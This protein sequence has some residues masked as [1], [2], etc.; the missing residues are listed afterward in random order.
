MG[1][2][3]AQNV[4]LFWG[5]KLVEESEMELGL[6]LCVHHHFTHTILHS[7]LDQMITQLNIVKI[8]KH[9]RSE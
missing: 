1:K 9:L 4:N 2:D 3:F 7:A 5:G 6:M 8:A